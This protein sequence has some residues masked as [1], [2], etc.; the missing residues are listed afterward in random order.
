M[1]GLFLFL[2]FVTLLDFAVFWRHRDF[3]YCHFFAIFCDSLG[4]GRK[5]AILARF[6]Q[7]T[8]YQRNITRATVLQNGLPTAGDVI[9]VSSQ[10]NI[11]V[12]ASR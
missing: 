12:F 3:S 2:Q 1:R 10:R 8:D 7:P 6:T 9:T 4:N 5:F 11:N